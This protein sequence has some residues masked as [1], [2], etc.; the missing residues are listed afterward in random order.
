MLKP[1]YSL[2]S[3]YLGA[4]PEDKELYRKIYAMKESNHAFH[5][6]NQFLRHLI[7]FALEHDKEIKR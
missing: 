3:I 7:E 5:S 6:M 1:S 2:G 4:S